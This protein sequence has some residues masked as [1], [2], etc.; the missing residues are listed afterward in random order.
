VKEGEGKKRRG[1]RNDEGKKGW[2]KKKP[3][4][5]NAKPHPPS[6]HLKAQKF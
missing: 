4:K 3:L 1:Q 6:R 5:G 2:E